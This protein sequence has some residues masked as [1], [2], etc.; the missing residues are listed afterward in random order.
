[1]EENTNGR[2][3][4]YGRW[5]KSEYMKHSLFLYYYLLIIALFS[6]QTTV[7]LLLPHPVLEK[8]KEEMW[9][10]EEQYLVK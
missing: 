2:K 1:M 10:S 4:R 7:N 3:H 8:N 9:K 5:G 6:T